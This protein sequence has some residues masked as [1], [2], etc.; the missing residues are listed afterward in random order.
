MQDKILSQL[1]TKK[2][3]IEALYQALSLRT[4][5]EYKELAKTLNQMEEAYLINL[6]GDF[7]YRALSP[8]KLFKGT[9]DLK[10]KGYGFLIPEA[11]GYDDIYIPA[12]KT[13]GAMDKDTVLVEISGAFSRRVEGQ[14]IKIISRYTQTVLGTLIIKQKIAYVEPLDHTIQ[15]PIKIKKK[16]T[17]GYAH[18]DRVEVNIYSYQKDHLKG[19][20]TRKI[21]SRN[22]ADLNIQTKILTYGFDPIFSKALLQ[23]ADKL[24]MLPDERT[25]LTHLLTFTI[26][27]KDAKDFDDAISL[28]SNQA[29]TTLYVHI[30][31]VSYFVKPGSSLDQEA[32]HRG[33]SVY[34]PTRVLPMLP[35]KLSNELCSLKPGVDRYTLTCQM[36]FNKDQ[37]LVD[38]QLYPS[39]I[40]SDARLT[41]QEV[42]ALLAGKETSI[43][44]SKL[45]ETLKAFQTFA[46]KLRDRRFE[47][48]SLNF[49]TDEYGFE[50]KNHKATRLFKLERG[51]AEKM[52]EEAMLMANQVVARHLFKEKIPSLYRIHDAPEADALD[53]LET[54]AQHFNFPVSKPLKSQ[55]NLKKLIDAM[56]GTPYEK[57]FTMVMLRSMQ[58]AIYAAEKSPHFGLG[59]D[60]YTH[61]TSPIRRYPDLMVHR[62][63]RRFVFDQ[64][65]VQER[66]L[67]ESMMPSVAIKTSAQERKALDLE[68]DVISMH[69][70][71][72]MERKIGDIFPATITSVVPF[73]LYVTLEDGIEGLIHISSLETYFVYDEK[74]LSLKSLEADTTYQLGQT[75]VVQCKKVNVFEGEI[76]FVLG[77]LS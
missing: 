11:E 58:K 52:I 27:G 37:H 21:G 53:K 17:E 47:Q 38:Y 55:K 39:K 25:D 68:R 71:E 77:D 26:D 1:K 19:Q 23:E 66:Q 31:D 5:E 29:S 70:A 74:T 35:E 65:P 32:L 49:E 75:L 48:G 22:D 14:V 59:F 42:N 51:D 33:T 36:E 34:L 6:D 10:Q 62:V 56:T 28:V 67:Y 9:L 12:H 3:S 60:D 13:F 40:H 43:K 41:Y 45:V 20:I 24:E 46:F 18:L 57:G 73:G 54:I 61:F 63:L 2:M 72:I 4:A 44:D 30:A 7:K 64:A 76:D 15:V 16:H 50:L 8:T 69:K